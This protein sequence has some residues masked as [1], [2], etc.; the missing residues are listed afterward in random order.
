MGDG[1]GGGGGASLIK[2]EAGI[3]VQFMLGIMANCMQKYEELCKNVKTASKHM[4][5]MKSSATPIWTPFL[6]ICKS[7]INCVGLGSTIDEWSTHL[8]GLDNPLSDRMI[9]RL[10]VCVKECMLQHS[11]L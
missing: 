8:S 1:G 10:D 9:T 2:A 5:V 11:M 3:A 7:M 4:C 6:Y